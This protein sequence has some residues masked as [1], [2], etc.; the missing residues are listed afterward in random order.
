MVLLVWVAE[1][2]VV[3][4]WF[5]VGTIVAVLI[6]NMVLVAV[7]IVV[8]LRNTDSI[9]RNSSRSDSKDGSKVAA[10][11]TAELVTFVQ[12]VLVFLMSVMILLWLT[13]RRH[14]T[15]IAQW[16]QK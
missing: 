9:S 12:A 1:V 6:A 16:Q 2:K 14:D 11:L 5:K 4:K 13:V 15:N 7:V 3:R 10:V 8:V